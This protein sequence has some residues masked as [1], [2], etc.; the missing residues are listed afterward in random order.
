MSLEARKQREKEREEEERRYEEERKKKAAERAKR[1]KEL[2][3]FLQK[4]EEERQKRLYVIAL[5]IHFSQIHDLW[6]IAYLQSNS[7]FVLEWHYS[8]T[9]NTFLSLLSRKHKYKH[10]HNKF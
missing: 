2:E 6:N 5:F 4:E 9:N 1:L 8:L 3:E 10:E 7:M